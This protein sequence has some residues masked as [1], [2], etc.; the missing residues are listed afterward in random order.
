MKQSIKVNLL[1]FLII[2]VIAFALSS[3]FASVVI[4]DN[5]DAKKITAIAN[6]SF[7][8]HQI[9][10]V[11][12]II[13]KVENKTT[14]NTTTFN[15]I[16]SEIIEVADDTWNLNVEFT[17]L[18]ACKKVIETMAHLTYEQS[19]ARLHIVEIDV[20]LHLIS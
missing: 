9:K 8:P 20:E 14:N 2:A 15:N 4:I 6:D 1:V 17:S 12:V 18:I 10:D 7:E 5:S 13:P 11:P 16:T 3:A 19:H